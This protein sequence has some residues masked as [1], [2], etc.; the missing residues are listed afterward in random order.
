MPSAAS[1]TSVGSVSLGASLE[2]A[3]YVAPS[4]VQGQSCDAVYNPEGVLV[5]CGATLV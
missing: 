5:D 4:Y 1:E 3:S 2:L